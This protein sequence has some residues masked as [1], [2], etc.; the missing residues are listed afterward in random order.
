LVGGGILSSRIFG[1]Q[2]ATIVFPPESII[3]GIAQSGA[4]GHEMRMAPL[5]GARIRTSFLHECR[6][7]TRP[8][9]S[10]ARDGQ[11]LAAGNRFATL[12]AREQAHLLEFIKCL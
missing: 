9:A 3:D 6:A 1:H 11:G 2:P 12:R 10:L 5:W 4:T 7:K 8:D